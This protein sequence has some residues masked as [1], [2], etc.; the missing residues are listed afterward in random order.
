M[1]LA[2]TA[3]LAFQ[4]KTFPSCHGAENICGTVRH[5][6]DD[7]CKASSLE[8][9]RLTHAFFYRMCETFRE[10]LEAEEPQD[11]D[12]ALHGY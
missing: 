8:K 6:A 9:G 10:N 7:F 4:Q 3:S 5:L 11:F 2:F 1:Q 12:D